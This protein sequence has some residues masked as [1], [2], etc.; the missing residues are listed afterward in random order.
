MFEE[1]R[2]LLLGRYDKR[3]FT[4]VKHSFVV[5][6]DIANQLMRRLAAIKKL[7]GQ[8]SSKTKSSKEDKR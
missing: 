1:I 7:P 4:P 8:E 6:V 3:I 5:N 2:N